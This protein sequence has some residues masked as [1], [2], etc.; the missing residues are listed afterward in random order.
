MCIHPWLLSLMLHRIPCALK[1][2][3]TSQISP[4]DTL[5]G[6]SDV[7]CHLHNISIF[8]CLNAFNKHCIHWRIFAFLTPSIANTN[9]ICTSRSFILSAYP[10]WNQ[11]IVIRNL[12][13]DVFIS[14][15]PAFY[16]FTMKALPMHTIKMHAYS[17]SLNMFIPQ[18]PQSLWILLAPILISYKF[19]SNH[20]ISSLASRINTNSAN[21]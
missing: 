4:Y 16:A 8:E 14:V 1:K 2:N 5:I 15:L 11:S 19:K 7:N 18:M 9:N 10:K 6:F 20:Y 13:S 17:C 12:N 3:I 21:I